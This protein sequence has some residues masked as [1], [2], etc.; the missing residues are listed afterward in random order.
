[1][2]AK[3]NIHLP[4]NLNVLGKILL[5]M[6]QIVA[7]L[8]PEYDMQKTVKEYVKYLMQKKVKDNIKPGNLMELFLEMKDL[9][10]NLPF[11]L[12]KFSERSEERRVGKECR[13]W[14]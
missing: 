12:N 10:E 1:M 2:A 4:V 7:T 11:R 6:D 5:N 9:T 3:Q 13:L 8:T 14:R